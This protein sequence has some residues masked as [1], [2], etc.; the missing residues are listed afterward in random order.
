MDGD[1]RAAKQARRAAGVYEDGDDPKFIQGTSK[2]IKASGNR[3][4][5]RSMARAAG[6]S[7]KDLKFMSK[8]MQAAIKKFK[9][10][11]EAKEAVSEQ[12]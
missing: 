7:S 2:G 10:A 12:A 6:M 5:M 4:I 11:N 3:K 8:K 9:A 1:S